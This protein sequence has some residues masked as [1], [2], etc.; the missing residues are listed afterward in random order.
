[1]FSLFEASF[2]EEVG[3]RIAGLDGLTVTGLR[4]TNFFARP[5]EFVSGAGSPPIALRPK[6]APDM[7]SAREMERSIP[8]SLLLNGNSAPSAMGWLT[9][10]V[11]SLGSLRVRNIKRSY[12]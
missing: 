10:P 4:G 8:S 7:Y 6:Q 1:M 9:F 5:P 11:V 2:E 3:V 12:K